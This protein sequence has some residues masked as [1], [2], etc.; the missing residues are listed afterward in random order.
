[1]GL[2]R[3]RGRFRCDDK[4]KERFLG[5]LQTS[6]GVTRRV[7]GRREKQAYAEKHDTSGQC[8]VV[9]VEEILSRGEVFLS[10]RRSGGEAR[11]ESGGY[12]V[13]KIH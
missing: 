4:M 13:Y 2:E 9:G 12:V 8:R 5:L 10:V 3:R 6:C 7:K 1:M 11:W